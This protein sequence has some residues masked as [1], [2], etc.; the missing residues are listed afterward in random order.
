MK[1]ALIEQ[2][3]QQKLSVGI[4]SAN[5]LNFSAE[6]QTLA[7]NKINVLHFDIADG[8]F[9]PMF[10]VGT[11]AI[12]SFPNDYFKDVHLMVEDQFV[13][14]KSAVANGANLVTLQLEQ[15]A[16][17]AAILE[18]LGEQYNLYQGQNY[19]VLRGLSLC[20]DTPV[21]Q[22]ENYLEQIDVIQLLTLDPRTGQKAAKELILARA[23]EVQQLLS[24]TRSQKLIKIDGSMNLELAEYFRSHSDIDWI[25]SGSALFTN[26]L[27]ASLSQWKLVKIF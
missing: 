3:Q 10:T 21:A 18:W 22:L 26:G 16:D 2:L 11:G 17:L 13:V 15:Q 23:A 24:A 1:Q 27:A 7:E 19:P 12:K 4:L 14:A 6:L 8:Q 9:S 5:W 25:V 20:P